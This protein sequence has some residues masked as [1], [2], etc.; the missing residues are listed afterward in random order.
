MATKPSHNL[1][2]Q[3][4]DTCIELG[5][6]REVI[7]HQPHLPADAWIIGDDDD[8]AG[9]NPAKF[10]HSRLLFVVPMMEAEN[11]HR[12]IHRLVPQRKTTRRRTNGRSAMPWPLE[13]HD[14]A[15]LNG[16]HVAILRFIRSGACPHVDD[17]PGRPERF[18]NP[19]K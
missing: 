3:W 11:G 15:W 17:R 16:H 1:L 18:M 9:S 5:N 2:G 8:G 12:G 13:S 7:V 4:K 6:F 19:F 14:I 10:T